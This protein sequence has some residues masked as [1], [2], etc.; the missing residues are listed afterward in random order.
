MISPALLHFFTSTHLFPIGMAPSGFST[1]CHVPNVL[2]LIKFDLYCTLPFRPVLRFSCLCQTVQI[3]LW[4]D[5]KCFFPHFNNAGFFLIWESV[6]ILGLVGP[7]FFISLTP[8]FLINP[9]RPLS[10]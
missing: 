1:S 6:T 8:S 10:F 7:L 5:N 2:E 9:S 4:Y 3:C